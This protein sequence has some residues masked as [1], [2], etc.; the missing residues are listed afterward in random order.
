MK[1]LIFI[2]VFFTSLGGISNDI[3]SEKIETEQE[4]ILGS[5]A[6]ASIRHTELDVKGEVHQKVA[7]APAHQSILLVAKN[8]IPTEL[9]LRHRRLTL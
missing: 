6:T 8:I 4:D 1:G 2:L 5:V 9:Y 7:Y 3:G